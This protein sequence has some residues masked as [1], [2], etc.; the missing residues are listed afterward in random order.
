MTYYDISS[1]SL[2]YPFITYSKGSLGVSKQ[3]LY[4]SEYMCT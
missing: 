3:F 4:E 2:V 1:R